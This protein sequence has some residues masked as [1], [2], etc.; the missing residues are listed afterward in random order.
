MEKGLYYAT[1]VIRTAVD[2][3]LNE[4]AHERQWDKINEEYKKEHGFSLGRESLSLQ[5]FIGSDMLIDFIYLA[6]DVENGLP[7]TN[8]YWIRSMGTQC[9]RNDKDRE[10]NRVFSDILAKLSVTF[11]G[12]EFTD[13]H[14]IQDEDCLIDNT[15][16]KENKLYK[17]MF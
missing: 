1:K 7:F 17:Y 8:E 11:D 10:D 15:F 9:I 3:F 2:N 16:I 4:Y 12:K 13:I 6:R 14:W 5:S